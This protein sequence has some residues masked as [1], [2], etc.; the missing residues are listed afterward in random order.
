MAAW[1]AGVNIALAAACHLLLP[2]RWAVVGMAVAYTLSCLAGL[3]LTARL[4]RRRLGGR[5]DDGGPRRTYVKLLCAA[6][7]AAA[8]GWAAA[9]ACDG[10]GGGTGPTAVA[11]TAGVLTTAL[12]YLLLARLMELD[13]LRRLP[14]M[15]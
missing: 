9:R 3:A 8:L 2:A 12:G 13:E 14:G 4:L 1:I 7:P 11:L 10:L 6:G 5:V 15:R